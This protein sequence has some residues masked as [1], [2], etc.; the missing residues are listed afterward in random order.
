MSRNSFSSV[1]LAIIA[2]AVFTAILVPFVILRR[3]DP[4]EVG[5]L[6]D[7]GGGTFTGQPVIKKVSTSR[8]FVVNPFTQKLAKYPVRQQTLELKAVVENDVIVGG[9]AAKCSDSGGIPLWIDTRVFYHVDPAHPGELFQLRPGY[10]LDSGNDD[11]E[12]DDG[13]IESEIVLP[14]TVGA[15]TEICS[16]YVYTSIYGEYKTEFRERVEVMLRESLAESYILLDDFIMGDINSTLEIEKSLSVK[17]EEQQKAAAAE[18]Q[19]D[20]KRTQAQGAADSVTIAAQGDA[21][22]LLIEVAARAEAIKID[23]AA[24]ADA[25]ALISAELEKHGMSLKD[26]KWLEEWDGVTPRT[27]VISDENGSPLMTID[28]TSSEPGQ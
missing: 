18:Y 3:V 25:I 22:A 10:Q 2:I 12:A 17:S 8:Y 14:K 5:V 13:D 23:A 7:Y 28:L 24:Q 15:I 27:L 20:Q 9:D 26:W 19:A 1:F 6:V 21:D 4:G 11:I 16:K